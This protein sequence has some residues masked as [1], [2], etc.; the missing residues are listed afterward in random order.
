MSQTWS[1]LLSIIGVVGLF[2]TSTGRVWG[3]WVNIGAQ[4]LW[5]VYATVTRQYG[6]LFAAVAYG[7]VFTLNLRRAL[8]AR[9]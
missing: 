2:V 6:F 8:R 5:I 1:W 3:W 9:A 7:I 4:M